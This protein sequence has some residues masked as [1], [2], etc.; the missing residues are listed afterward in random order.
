MSNAF[1][2]LF[3]VVQFRSAQAPFVKFQRQILPTYLSSETTQSP[4]LR[5]RDLELYV[6]RRERAKFENPKVR[7]GTSHFKTDTE[8]SSCIRYGRVKNSRYLLERFA[9]FIL[10]VLERRARTPAFKVDWRP[11]TQ[12]LQNVLHGSNVA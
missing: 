8:P 12:D 10:R 9:D 1:N 2:N 11:R 6:V 7:I 4:W 3:S 5:H